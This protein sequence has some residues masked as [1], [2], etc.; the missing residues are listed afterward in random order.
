MNNKRLTIKEVATMLGCNEQSVRELCKAKLLGVALPPK[1]TRNK[2]QYFI[3]E[4]QVHDFM[5]GGNNG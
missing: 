4:S 1:P 2:W 5:K 3:Y